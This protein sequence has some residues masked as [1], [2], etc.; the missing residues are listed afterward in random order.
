MKAIQGISVFL[1]VLVSIPPLATGDDWRGSF[2]TEDG[3]RVVTNPER[4][5]ESVEVELA[6]VW[7]RGTA[8]D[9]IFFGMPVR[10][11]EDDAGNVYVLDSQVSE[12]LVFSP[13][14]EYL[15]TVGREGEGP[16]EFR[17]AADMFLRP[18]G[19]IGVIVVFPGIIVQLT[20]DG[21]PAGKFPVPAPPGGGFQ[22]IYMGRAAGDRLVLSGAIQHRGGG[23]REMEQEYYLKAL[24]Y[25]GN[26]VAQ[27]HSATGKTL[28]GGMEFDERT[29]S[30]GTHQWSAAPDGRVAAAP[31]FDEYHVRVWN[32]D[33]SL[34]YVIQRPDY[35]PLERSPREKKRFQ[36]LYD[37]IIRWNPDSSFETSETHRA[38]V[39]VYFRPDGSLWVLPGRGVWAREDDVFAAFDVYDQEGRFMRRVSLAGPGGVDEDGVYLSGNHLY[40]V[41][42]Q[43]SAFMASFAGG[44]VTVDEDA[45][46]LQ[47]VAYEVDFP[48]L[49]ANR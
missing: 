40:R 39:Q 19:V 27:Y 45:E 35:R 30:P 33:G 44:D 8:D 48:T 7:R 17:N 11:V 47:V 1:A 10:V 16:G 46:P 25:D 24:D 4:P 21:A 22:L 42:E 36:K 37:G 43:F 2:S 38:V 29:F 49:G 26:V 12:I 32:A 9:D 34:A 13:E 28:F 41:S 6:E 20:T 18:D 5:V 14:G 15:R 23:G 31:S 3:I